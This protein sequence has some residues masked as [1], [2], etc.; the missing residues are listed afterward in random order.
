MSSF[1]GNAFMCSEIEYI[2]ANV[3]L[4]WNKKVR[5]ERLE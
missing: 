4:K 5:V 1:S 2:D 3:P